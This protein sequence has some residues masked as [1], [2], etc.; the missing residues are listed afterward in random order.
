MKQ[1]EQQGDA[2]EMPGFFRQVTNWKELRF[3]QKTE[4]L[5][6]LT[7]VFCERFLPKYRDRT[8]DQMIQAARSGKQNIVEGAEDGKMS[9]EME[10]KLFNVARASIGELRQDFGDYLK[11]RHLAIWTPTDKRFGPMQDFTKTHNTLSDYEPYFHRWSAEEM[12][13]IGLTLCYQVDVMMNRYLKTLE[14]T[15]IKEGGV[16]ERMHKARTEFRKQQD[17]RRIQLEQTVPL[18]QQQLAAAQEEAAKWKAAY[19]DLKQRAIKAYNSQQ[20]IIEELEKKLQ[21]V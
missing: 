21:E 20:K 8:V 16:K 5:Y 10:L 19:E 3:Y 4:V 2:T 17:N 18:L 14:E 13:N 9:N 1:G 12:A 11:S 15:F 7:Y 6:Q